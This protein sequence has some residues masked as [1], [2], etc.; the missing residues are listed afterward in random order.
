MKCY[1]LIDFG[2]TYTKLTAV[3]LDR[4][5]ILGTTRSFTTIREGIELGLRQ[6]EAKL[7]QITGPLSY[8][9][10]LACSSAAGGLRMVAVGL[11]PELTVEAAR[12]AALGAGARVIG[13]YGYCLGPGEMASI[14]ASDPDLLILAGGT[15]G[16]DQQTMLHNAKVLSMSPLRSPVIIAGNRE[17]VPDA[18]EILRSHG[19]VCYRVDNVMPGRGRVEIA[20]VQ[21]EIRRI[22]LERIIQAKGLDRVLK[23]IDGIMMPTPSSVLAAAEC[24][25]EGDGVRQGLGELALIDIGGA[26]TDLHTIASGLP[27]KP[28]VSLKG[29]PEPHVKRTVEGDLGM[30]Y[31]AYSLLEHMGM[32]RLV[33]LSGL[34]SELIEAGIARRINDAGYIPE[35]LEEVRLDQ[36][37]GFLAAKGAADRHVGL[38]EIVN[39]PFGTTYIQSGKDLTELAHV[40][41][42]GGVLA[43]ED[44]PATILRGMLFDPAAPERLK[45][46][47]PRF[48]IDRDYVLTTLGLLVKDEPGPALDLLRGALMEIVVGPQLDTERDD[49]R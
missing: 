1:L 45:P 14:T 43:A 6:A 23:D 30:R 5:A 15:D 9:R 11:V 35:S 10:K 4:P 3:D 40:I 38:M 7:E 44:D 21:A 42:T 19:K 2:S 39:T 37:L 49:D 33:D 46:R 36:T 41:G 22:F 32:E 13:T 27:T 16:G 20:P 28:H 26:T 29:L 24:L 8:Q 18:E 17:A 25:A 34:A 31:S 12:R 48:W 47:H